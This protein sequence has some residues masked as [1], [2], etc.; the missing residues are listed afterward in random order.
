MMSTNFDDPTDLDYA[1]YLVR[2]Q[3]ASFEEAVSGSG[4]GPAPRTA[5]CGQGPATV[6]AWSDYFAFYQEN[7]RWAWR[8]VSQSGTVVA[9]SSYTFRYYLECTAD[10]KQHGWQGQPLPVLAA[11]GLPNAGLG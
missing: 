2:V 3:A 5:E 8:R 6:P 9:I 7:G 10:A 1:A 4:V 11:C